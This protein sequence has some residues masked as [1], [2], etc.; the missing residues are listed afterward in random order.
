[1][2]YK[3]NQS[4]VG[5]WLKRCFEMHFLE[6]TEAV[7]CFLEDILL[8]CP[9]EQNCQKFADYLVENYVTSFP[10]DM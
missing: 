7:E 2:Q 3:D 9:C 8:D 5:K 1:M 6:S 10:P 4:D